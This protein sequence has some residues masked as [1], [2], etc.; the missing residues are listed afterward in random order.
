MLYAKT[1]CRMLIPFQRRLY[2]S[3]LTKESG[4]AWFWEWIMFR[5]ES[6][7][8]TEADT[9]VAEHMVLLTAQVF[10]KGCPPLYLYLSLS[11]SLSHSLS[12][13]HQPVCLQHFLQVGAMINQSQS[14]GREKQGR[15]G[16]PKWE[17]EKCGEEEQFL[18]SSWPLTPVLCPNNRNPSQCI[19]VKEFTRKTWEQQIWQDVSRSPMRDR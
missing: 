18:S 9:R 13:T 10:A 8:R 1:N 12:H 16:M 7:L 2:G 17:R 14:V 11:L 4:Q 3:V 19:F 6:E 5:H 15:G